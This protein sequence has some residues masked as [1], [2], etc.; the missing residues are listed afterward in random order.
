MELGVQH[1]FSG[2]VTV[3][4]ERRLPER[5]TPA[6]Y[7]ALIDVYR[8]EVPLPRTLAAIG[9]RHRRTTQGGWRI[10]TPRYAPHPTLQGH[11]TFALKYEGLDLAVLKRLF[12]A[13]GADEI[14]AVVQAAPTGAYARRIWFLYEWLMGERLELPDAKAGRYVPVVDP[15]L[16]WALA[17]ENVSRQRVRDNLPGTPAF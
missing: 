8:L 3:L 12:V 2:P 1:R 6:G 9:E 10:L 16:Q 13:A 11:L 17:G 4:H 14:Q 7:S 5:A 15:D